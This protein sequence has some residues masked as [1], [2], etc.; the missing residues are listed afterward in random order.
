MGKH[1]SSGRLISHANYEKGSSRHNSRSWERLAHL[2]QLP[3]FLLLM[4]ALWG[5]VGFGFIAWRVSRSSRPQLPDYMFAPVLVSYSYFEKDAIQVRTGLNEMWQLTSRRYCHQISGSGPTQ[6]QPDHHQQLRFLMQQLARDNRGLGRV[7]QRWT[8]TVV[9]ARLQGNSGLSANLISWAV[10]PIGAWP[11]CLQQLGAISPP[12][13]T[14]G[15]SNHELITSAH[16][17]C[18][19]FASEAK[20]WVYHPARLTHDLILQLATLRTP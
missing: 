4:I 13:N 5:A 9:S 1:S 10:Q 12:C 2:P 3:L 18:K 11:F 17:L 6:H 15:N 16:S 7:L 14:Q 20:A 8:A 19:W